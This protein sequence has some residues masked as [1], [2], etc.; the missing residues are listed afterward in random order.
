MA[1]LSQLERVTFFNNQLQGRIV[2]P[3]SSPKLR[4]ALL[5]NNRLMPLLYRRIAHTPVSCLQIPQ[6]V[7]QGGFSFSGFPRATQPEPAGSWQSAY[8]PCTGLGTYG[9]RQLHVVTCLALGGVAIE[10]P[11]RRGWLGCAAASCGA[12]GTVHFYDVAV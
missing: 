10:R 9:K 4:M 1:H 2:L 12:P 6:V 8:G 3:K 5:H 11:H 7:V